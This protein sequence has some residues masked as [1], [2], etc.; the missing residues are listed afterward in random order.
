MKPIL[1]I[2][3]ISK[4]YRLGV[5]NSTTLS[6]DIKRFWYNIRGKEDPFLKIGEENNRKK[7]VV[8]MFGHLKTS[9]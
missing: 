9:I 3:S 4:M 7:T 8:N 6:D 5:V 2:K 1:E